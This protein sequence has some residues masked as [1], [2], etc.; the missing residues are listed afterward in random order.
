MAGH[1]TFA[2]IKPDAVGKNATGP[3]L[4]II[5][6]SGFIIKAMKYT[7]L[8]PDLAARFYAVHRGKPFYEGLIGFMCSG[9]VVPMILEKEN[10]VEAFRS[11]IGSTD[12][13]NA[14]P[15]TIR[16][17]FAEN[18]QRNAVHG[19]DSDENAVIECGFFFSETERF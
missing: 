4:K 18:V 19:S 5:N 14:E 10:A 16:K 13:E 1:L 9:P 8:T 15:G 17:L 11:L 12:P 7:Q 2:M 3:I 6:E